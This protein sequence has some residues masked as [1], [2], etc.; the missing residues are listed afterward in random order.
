MAVEGGKE[1]FVSHV[2]VA[3]EVVPLG[4]SLIPE[5]SLAWLEQGGKVR[6]KKPGNIRPV[7]LV[8]LQEQLTVT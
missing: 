1:G 4:V 2:P 7:L 3:L 6:K 5:F 8:L